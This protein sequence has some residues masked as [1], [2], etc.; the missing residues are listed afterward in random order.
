LG[1]NWL[2]CVCFVILALCTFS[3]ILSQFVLF[4]Y[5]SPAYNNDWEDIAVGPCAKG[6]QR[7]CIYIL[8]DG[9]YHHGVHKRTIYRVVEP[10]ALVNQTVAP[11]STYKYKLVLIFIS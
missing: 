5:S 3:K 10:D 9:N 2:Q 1:G 7:T 6:E 8:D 11:D 4:C